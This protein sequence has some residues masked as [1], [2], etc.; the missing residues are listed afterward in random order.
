ML[1]LLRAISQGTFFQRPLFCM[2]FM[3]STVC[4]LNTEAKFHEAMYVIASSSAFCLGSNRK[5]PLDR[6]SPVANS[7]TMKSSQLTVRKT[8]ILGTLCLETFVAVEI[9]MVRRQVLCD[10]RCSVA[11]TT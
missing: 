5:R 2:R 4:E 8:D 3:H 11:T 6:R 7:I 9:G 10:L 1:L